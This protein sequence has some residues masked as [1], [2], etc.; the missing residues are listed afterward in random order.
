MLMK[1][2][3]LSG[4]SRATS[5]PGSLTVVYDG[6][7]VL[8]R[9]SVH[10]LS[11]QRQAVPIRSIAASSPEAVKHFGYLPNYGDDMIVSADDG[12]IWVGPPD[13]Y[14]AVMWAIPHLRALSYV[15]AIRLLKPVVRR[16]FQLVT[17]NRQAIG[18]LLG[19]TCE[20]CAVG[21]THEVSFARQS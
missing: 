20:R 19:D 18:S 8:C 2:G 13:A 5:K 12:R 6:E 1:M 7:C 14:L 21:P 4:S 10:W 17:G 16:V 3:K 11:E 15:L 9:R